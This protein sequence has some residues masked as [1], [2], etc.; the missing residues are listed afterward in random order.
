M[1]E[2]TKKLIGQYHQGD[3]VKIYIMDVQQQQNGSD[4]G[5]FA[6]AF[7]KAI[8]MGKDPTQLEFIDPR[9]HLA[10]HLPEG[11]IP[12]FPAVTRN[13][14]NKVL[15]KEVYIKLKEVPVDHKEKYSLD[16]LS[17]F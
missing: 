13:C 3:K 5:A 14:S 15:Q 9:S 6:V 7:A 4:C 1:D 2:N 17:L 8:L 16:I 12:E 10:L 11:S